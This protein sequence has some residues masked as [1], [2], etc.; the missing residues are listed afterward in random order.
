M[1]ERFTEKARQVV[2]CAQDEAKT[3]K[4]AYIG[5]EHLL[6]GLLLVEDGLGSY[7]LRDMGLTVEQVREDVRRIVGD[8]EQL[9]VGQIPFTPRSK[10]I[11]ELSLREALGLGHNYIGTEH[12]LLALAREEQGVSARI[13]SEHAI[14]PEQVRERILQALR[15]VPKPAPEFNRKLVDLVR[16]A[17]DL[18]IDEG[19]WDIAAALRKIERQ[20]QS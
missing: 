10:K 5:T 16:S 18:A 6:L 3:F 4:H 1:F 17:K 20:L 19:E 7:V 8:G 9:I 13:L 12:L 14:D 15:A 11:L 2:V